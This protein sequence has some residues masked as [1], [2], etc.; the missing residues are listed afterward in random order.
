MEPILPPS[1][2][3]PRRPLRPLHGIPEAE[4]RSRAGPVLSGLLHGVILGALLLP[5]FLGRVVLD[6]DQRGAGGAGPAGG[7]GGGGFRGRG[8]QIRAERIRFLQLSPA[9]TPPQ[10]SSTRTTPAPL[11]PPP[12]RDPEPPVVRAEPEVAPVTDGTTIPTA[13][14]GGGSGTDGTGGMGPGRGGGIGTGVGTGRGSADGPGTGGG[15]RDIHP[16][17][18]TNLAILPI[19]VP[20]RVRPYKMVASFEVDERGQARL[21]GFNPSRDAGYNR[22]IREMLAEVRFRPAT[23]PDGT[24]VRDT[25]FITAE[26]PR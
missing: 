13:G 14:A 22:K 8:G 25:A 10:P 4:R 16:P 23:R 21:L 9:P 20:N 26:A 5:A 1:S 3:K 17:T 24:P 19:P 15:G 18:V 7:G 12:E 2:A 11:P 6:A